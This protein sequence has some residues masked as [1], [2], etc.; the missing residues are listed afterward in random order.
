MFGGTWT[1]VRYLCRVIISSSLYKRCNSTIQVRSNSNLSY[2]C[3][4][5]NL[6]NTS[7]FSQH[8]LQIGETS[9]CTL[10]WLANVPCK[11]GH[12]WGQRCVLE[13]QWNRLVR[14]GRT[15]ILKIHQEHLHK[16]EN[17]I[18]SLQ[19]IVSSCL[20][21]DMFITYTTS[22]STVSKC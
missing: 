18:L 5:H 3:S 10:S 6:Q 20:L 19:E 8:L 17:K 14:C 16:L 2:F 22:Q 1:E 15:C 7:N 13:E 9:A 11:I 21:P 4:E 12:H